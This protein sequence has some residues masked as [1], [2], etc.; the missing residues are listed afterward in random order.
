MLKNG[1]KGNGICIFVHICA[2][3]FMKFMMDACLG[4]LVHR[5]NL[6]DNELLTILISC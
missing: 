6:H 3:I 2:G 5:Q 4:R 1:S